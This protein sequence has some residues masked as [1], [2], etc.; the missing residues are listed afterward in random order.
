MKR[1]ILPVLWLVVMAACS[2]QK[3]KDAPEGPQKEA[4]KSWDP[5]AAGTVVDKI[6]E[7]ITEDEL[8]NTYFRV[9]LST[10]A[11]S[12]AGHY[13]LK[14]EHGFNINETDIDL[15]KWVGGATVKPVLQKG[16]GKY[17]CL[18]GFDAG[19][20]QFHELYQV[21]V[22]SGSIA[23]KQTKRYYEVPSGKAATE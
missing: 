15:P 17:S 11:T 1:K 12:K 6:E 18:V 3:G 19:D 8:N 20:G 23:L 4:I 9:T 22:N 5:P 7:R 13:T 10:T 16:A 14:L 2:Q 21:T